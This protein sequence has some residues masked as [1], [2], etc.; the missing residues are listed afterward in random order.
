[1]DGIRDKLVTGV[2]TCALPIFLPAHAAVLRAEDAV[3][4]LTPDHRG[5][6]RAGD[7]A[8]HILRHRILAPVRRHIFGIEPL[9][10]DAPAGPAIRSEERRVGKE[11]R[12]RWSTRQ[13]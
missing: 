2:Q 6:A 1:E 10:A 8:V 13:L 7:E 4:V 5:R 11:C 3:M 9:P 12:T